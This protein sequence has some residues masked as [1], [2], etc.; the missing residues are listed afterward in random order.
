MKVTSSQRTSCGAKIV[1]KS[2]MSEAYA[3]TQACRRGSSGS[4]PSA[5]IH[6]RW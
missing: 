1:S 4:V 2:D 3:A 6:S 5:L